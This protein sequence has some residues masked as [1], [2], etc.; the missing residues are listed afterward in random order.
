[1]PNDNTPDLIVLFGTALALF[2]NPKLAAV[3]APYVVIALGALLGT[4]W[5]I[6]RRPPSTTRKATGGFAAL[7]LGT[8]FVLTMPAAVWLERYLGAGSPQWLLGPL[9]ALIAGIG[10]DWPSVAGWFVN[11]GR[12]LIT[13]RAGIDE[14]ST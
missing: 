7:M 5:A 13:K 2:F 11:I 14:G 10:D 9:A 3:L 12:R 8:S 1:M 4:G 6:Y